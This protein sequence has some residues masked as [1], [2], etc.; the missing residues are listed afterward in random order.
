MYILIIDLYLQYI[1]IDVIYEYRLDMSDVLPTLA[2][3]FF[4]VSAGECFGRPALGSGGC[5]CL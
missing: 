4:F 3:L 2:S 5:G 1:Y